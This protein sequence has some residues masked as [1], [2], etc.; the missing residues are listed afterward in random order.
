MPLAGLTLRRLASCGAMRRQTAV[1]WT[2]L[3]L[4]PCFPGAHQCAPPALQQ[5][6]CQV[7]V[8]VRALAMTSISEQ[9]LHKALKHL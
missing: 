9:R 3:E 1:D 8:R 5:A 4:V 6:I 2:L 7:Q